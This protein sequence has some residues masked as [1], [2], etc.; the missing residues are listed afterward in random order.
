MRDMIR[1]LILTATAFLLGSAVT[2]SAN[3]PDPAP[4][5]QTMPQ[6]YQCTIPVPADT[7]KIRVVYTYRG[8]VVMWD[9]LWPRNLPRSR[10]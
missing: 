5:H 3:A 6:K 9:D 2:A 1:T 10:P 4:C 8:Q 7:Y